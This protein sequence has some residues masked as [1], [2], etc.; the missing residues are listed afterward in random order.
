[1][2]AMKYIVVDRVLF[3]RASWWQKFLALIVGILVT[4]GAVMV[5]GVMILF[6]PW[7]FLLCVGVPAIVAFYYEVELWYIVGLIMGASI[8]IAHILLAYFNFL[9]M[10]IPIFH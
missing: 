8:F 9:T 2:N 3:G 4:Y 5:F 6:N 7:M 10:P 1:M